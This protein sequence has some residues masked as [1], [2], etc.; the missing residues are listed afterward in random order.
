MALA[1]NPVSFNVTYGATTTTETVTTVYLTAQNILEMISDLG[2]NTSN[3][4]V[5]IEYW[6]GTAKRRLTA[7]MP[8]TGTVFTFSVKGVEIT[9]ST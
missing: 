5:G 2:L 7:E 3:V 6:T 8:A 9:P 1:I 4:S